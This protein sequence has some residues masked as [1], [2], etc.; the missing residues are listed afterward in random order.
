MFSNCRHF[1]QSLNEW[2]VSE[3][4]NMTGMFNNCVEFNSPLNDWNLL[5][6][7]AINMYD[8][9]DGANSFSQPLDNWNIQSDLD[10]NDNVQLANILSHN[11]YGR[12]NAINGLPTIIPIG[13]LA[14][15]TE[16]HEAFNEISNKQINET[17]NLLNEQFSNDVN[18]EIM[19]KNY[20]W[21]YIFDHFEIFINENK[22]LF[23]DENNEDVSDL[24]KIIINKILEKLNLCEDV[25][26]KHK[27]LIGLIVRYVYELSSTDFKEQYTKQYLQENIRAYGDEYRTIN[28][29]TEINTENI[30]CIKGMKERFIIVIRDVV[31]AMCE[32]GGERCTQ[33]DKMLDKKLSKLNFND[34][35]QK[36]S[37]EHLSPEF[38][39]SRRWVEDNSVEDVR[40]DFIDYMT[41]IYIEH[42]KLDNKIAK[43]IEKS[44]KDLN[45]VFEK[46]EFGGRK[47]KNKRNKSKKIKK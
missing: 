31:H 18:F 28:R 46:L 37:E 26:N 39:N 30:S 16:I 15:A 45:Y 19:E 40:Q 17:I 38:I 32:F 35:V 8:M 43:Q 44:A 9:F 11:V 29:T 36:W 33:I 3:V 24:Y 7:L 5:N 13:D 20:F 21:K 14:R 22:N 1:N 41:Q 25:S 47:I 27:R 42:D 4:R 6:I 10:I 12:L 23:V 2:N 34:I